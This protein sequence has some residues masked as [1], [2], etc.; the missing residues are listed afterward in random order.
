MGIHQ[1]RVRAL[2]LLNSKQMVTQKDRCC[3]NPECAEVGTLIRPVNEEARL[4]LKGCGYGLDV[5]G[6]VGERHMHGHKSF[7]EIHEELKSDYGAL[8]SSRHVPNLYRLY[9]AIVGAR[10]LNSAAVLARL[11]AKKRLILSVDAVRFDDVSPALYV[12]REVGLGEILLAERIEKADADNCAE[13]MRKLEPIK[14]Y[15]AGIVS[16]KEKAMVSAIA[17][18]FPGIPHQYCQTHFYM[19]LVKPMESDLAALSSGVDAVAKGV[20]E[21]AQRLDTEKATPEEH[22]LVKMVCEAVQITS[23]SKGEKLFDPAPLKRFTKISSLHAMVEAAV[24]EKKEREKGGAWPLLYWLLARLALLAKWK[25][26]AARLAGQVQIVREIAHLLNVDTEGKAVQQNLSEFLAKLKKE[27][28]TPSEDPARGIFLQHVIAVTERF[29]S[30]LFA[31]YDVEG[32]PA[33]NNDLESFFR[34][35]KY[36]C[37]RVQGKKSTAGGPLESFGPLLVQLWPHLEKRPDLQAMLKDLSPEEVQKARD[38]LKSLAEPAR[39][40][41]SFRRDSDAHIQKALA[42]WGKPAELKVKSPTEE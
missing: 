25:D 21:I 16:D 6:M 15:V 30:G 32:L 10:T 4:V 9:L 31:C 33:N 13:F 14:A 7:G 26:L 38:G 42:K 28:A 5:I 3:G 40:R 11:K 17:V 18:V 8:I 39:K 2:Q 1:H 19:N 36:H 27:I 35:L 23:K 22:E 12:V 24:K 20:R 34:T 37:R 29:W 41:R